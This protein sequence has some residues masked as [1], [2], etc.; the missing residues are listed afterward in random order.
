MDPCDTARCLQFLLMYMAN[1][2]RHFQG[3]C[4]LATILFLQREQLVFTV[5][6]TSLEGSSKLPLQSAVHG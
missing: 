3:Y 5:R 1:L 6:I 2:R 4:Y